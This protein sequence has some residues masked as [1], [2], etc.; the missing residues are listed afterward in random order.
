MQEREQT[1]GR[2]T[3]HSAEDCAAGGDGDATV[4][5][6]CHPAVVSL[7]A[8]VHCYEAKLTDAEMASPGE[9]G[10]CALES[11]TE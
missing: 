6:N 1:S 11:A 3:I 9:T 10:Y 8:R 7:M 4:T 2:S 5:K